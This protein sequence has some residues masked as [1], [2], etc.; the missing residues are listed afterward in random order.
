MGH[1]YLLT[2]RGFTSIDFPHA[3]LT[4]GRD[5]NDQGH[6]VG[7]FRDEAGYVHGYLR[8]PRKAGRR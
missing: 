1:A 3:T 6:I 8:V 5:V 4:T 7:S 2:Q